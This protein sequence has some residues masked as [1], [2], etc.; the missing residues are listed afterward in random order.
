MKS[1]NLSQGLNSFALPGSGYGYT[2]AAIDALPSNE[3]TIAFGLFDESGSTRSFARQMEL[4]VQE[5]VRSLR[6]SADKI[7]YRHC[8]FDTEFREIHGY[9]PLSECL[10]TDYDGIWAGGGQT[11][12]FK[13]ED[14]VLAATL[15]YAEKQAAKKYIVN[16]FGYFMSDG[17]NYLPGQPNAPTQDDVRMRNARCIASESLESINTIMIGVN[18]D[19]GIRRE[20]EAHSNYV[21]FTQFIPIEKA[22]EKTLAKIM[23]FISRSLQATSV[24]LGSNGPSK[25]LTF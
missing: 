24:A 17:Q 1:Q 21:G 9:K 23:G 7:I 18:A 25:S 15:D 4:C 5:F 11:A 3:N 14:N 22:D 20:L 10:E 12:L 19:A 8:H 6:H 2:G 13:S 16:A